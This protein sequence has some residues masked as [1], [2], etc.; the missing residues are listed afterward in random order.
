MKISP[1]LSQDIPLSVPLSL[2]C[3]MSFAET[4]LQFTS[5]KSQYDIASA[6]SDHSLQCPHEE[7]LAP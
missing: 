6:Q 1:K 2:L 4:L 3:V 7:S 5:L